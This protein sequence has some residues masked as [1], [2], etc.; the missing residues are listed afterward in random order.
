MRAFT[1]SR[2]LSQQGNVTAMKLKVGGCKLGKLSF[3]AVMLAFLPLEA[4]AQPDLVIDGTRAR[5]SIEFNRRTF[6]AQHCAYQEGC[7]W[8]FGTRKLLR[9]DV[10]VRNVGDS[11]LVIGDPDERTDIFTWSDCHDHYHLRGLAT[12]RIT[13]RDGRQVAKTYKQGFC[14]RDVH[15]AWGDAGPEQYTCDYQGISVGWQDTYDKSL[16]C[17][18]IDISH[19]PPGK[20]N[21]EITVNPSRIF[22]ETNY[23]NNRVIIPIKVPLKRYFRYYY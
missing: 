3:G 4:A 15:R 2:A 17:Q 23:K 14:L 13:T 6:S 5:Y 12:Y 7:V 1:H 18:W 22:E 19:V 11:D 16:D 8:N 20:Y 9:L 21:L 10:G